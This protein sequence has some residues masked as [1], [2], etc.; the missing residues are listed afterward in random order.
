[1]KTIK[2]L[3]VCGLLA[4]TSS[5]FAQSVKFTFDENVTIKPGE[6]AELNVAFETTDIPTVAGW[7]MSL[8]LPEG[9]EIY[10]DMED[11]DY[12][13]ELSSIHNAK[14]HSVEV[15]DNKD[16]SKL[17]LMSGGL[18]TVNMKA[19]T[20]DLCVITLKAADTFAGIGNAQVKGL[21]VSDDTGK[22][23]NAPDVEFTVTEEGYDPATGINSLNAADSNEPVFNLA[24]QQVGKNYKGIVVKNGKK[25]IVK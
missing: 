20:G 15:K 3:L 2:S 24:G 25:A 14:K 11:E 13:I 22:Q 7:Q 6:T 5:A 4:L 8:Y 1:M 10:Y 17:L 21:A 23:T 19:T 9:I 12:V 16:G 18:A